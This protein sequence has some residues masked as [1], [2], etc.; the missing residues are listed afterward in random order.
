VQYKEEASAQTR[1]HDNSKNTFR[2]RLLILLEMVLLVLALL[3]LV[4]LLGDRQAAAHT[5]SNREDQTKCFIIQIAN[6]FGNDAIGVLALLC[7]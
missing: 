4:C 5:L 1:H 7:Y 3:F 6:A 2:T